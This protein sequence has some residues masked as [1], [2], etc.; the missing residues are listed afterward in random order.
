MTSTLVLA[1]GDIAQADAGA[2]IHAMRYLKT[3]YDLPDT[4]YLDAAMPGKSLAAAIAAADNLIV[5]DA[6]QLDA[7]PGAVRVYEDGAVD[8]LL[9]GRQGGSKRD[10][11]LAKLMR[12]LHET[13][14][15][16]VRY[17]LIGIQPG[18][19]VTGEALSE[20][21]RRSMPRAAGNAATLVYRWRRPVRGEAVDRSLTTA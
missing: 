7:E 2:A 18:D 12:H 8:E 15:L 17:A 10:A 19:R 6:A 3:H 9:A 5:I 20:S 1:V 13:G 11:K 4:T 21:V 16:P 14:E